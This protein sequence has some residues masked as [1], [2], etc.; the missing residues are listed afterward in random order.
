MHN[1]KSVP[2]SPQPS[3]P[4]I[5]GIFSQTDTQTQKWAL[6]AYTSNPKQTHTRRK[7]SSLVRKIPTVEAA[8]LLLLR[9][10]SLDTNSFS[11]P[12][13]ITLPADMSSIPCPLLQ[14][15]KWRVIKP[16]TPEAPF[17]SSKY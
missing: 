17:S 13:N 15:E 5:L 9:N 16:L 10:Q 12:E 8:E 6:G 14:E 11:F 4:P 2:P 3:K 7:S 1:E